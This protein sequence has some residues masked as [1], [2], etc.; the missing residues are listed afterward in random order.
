MRLFACF[1]LST[2]FLAAT[3][4]F[5]QSDR[6]SQPI[7]GDTAS[8]GMDA[9]PGLI[10]GKVIRVLDGDTIN[11]QSRDR[12]IYTIR[13]QGVDSPEEKQPFGKKSRKNL[14]ELILDEGVKVVVHKKDQSGSLIGSVY[15]LGRDVGLL[16]IEW[17][18]AWHFKQ[19]A[20]EQTAMSRKTYAQAEVKARSERL[21]LWEKADAMPP[22]E[23]RGDKKVPD[24]VNVK[25]AAS[26]PAV[27]ANT[28]ERKYSLGPLGGCY[29]VSSSGRKVYV[30]DKS[31]CTNVSTGIKQ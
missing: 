18:L 5:A 6:T 1:I 19:Y 20:Y 15:L 11:I 2:L 22:W 17:G 24:P 14:Q 16:Q 21:G 26:V 9:N 30:K 4:C 3:V 12:T 10:E 27:P 29:Y 28:S 7:P 8:K 13:L 23:Y 31:L 25:A